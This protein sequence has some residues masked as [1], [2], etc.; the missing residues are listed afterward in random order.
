MATI[1]RPVV[2]RIWK[3]NVLPLFLTICR[4]DLHVFAASTSNIVDCYI[5]ITFRPSWE[6]EREETFSPVILCVVYAIYIRY[7]YV[8]HL[9]TNL[10]VS[11]LARG[12]ISALK[13]L[14]L[15]L[16]TRTR[17][18][19]DLNFLT[20]G[21]LFGIGGFISSHKIAHPESGDVTERIPFYDSSYTCRAREG[22]RVLIAFPTKR[23]P[24]KSLIQHE[25]YVLLWG[26]RHD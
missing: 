25:F 7:V 22:F 21:N 11:T 15:A 24:P 20:R 1:V 12:F 13:L 16:K 8:P 2:G 26:R 10:N 3:K 14:W 19:R 5:I 6:R 4:R 23:T 9:E 17:F 18:V